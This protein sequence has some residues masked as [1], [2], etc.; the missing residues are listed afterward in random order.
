LKE[1]EGS[2]DHFLD[3]FWFAQEMA[4][5]GAEPQRV[6]QARWVVYFACQRKGAL[7][8]ADGLLG[9]AQHGESQRVVGVSAN[10]WIMAGVQVRMLTMFLSIIEGEATLYVLPSA[11]EISVCEG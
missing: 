3:G 11:N 5:F 6:C 9:I 1:G 7:N 2:A 8:L 4:H 10:G